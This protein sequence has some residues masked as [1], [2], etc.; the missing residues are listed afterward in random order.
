MHNRMLVE[1]FC[2]AAQ[3]DDASEPRATIKAGS[4]S[5]NV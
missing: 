1:V 3:G 4:D 5:F 2:Y